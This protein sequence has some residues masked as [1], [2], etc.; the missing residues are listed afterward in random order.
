MDA[1]CI[2]KA[3]HMEVQTQINSMFRWF[4]SASKC[5]VFLSDVS[6]FGRGT[7]QA[8]WRTD[9]RRSRWFTRAWT[10]QELLAPR[11]VEFFSR[12]GTTLGTKIS[13]EYELQSITQLPLA[14][15]QGVSLDSFSVDERL[16]WVTNRCVVR[17]EDLAYSLLGIFGVFMPILYGEGQKSALSRLRRTIEDSMIISANG[18]RFQARD[19]L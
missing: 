17:Q 3:D 5:Y 15:L 18:K 2:N 16:S 9:F 10:L 4:N 8:S 7:G 6:A 11:H 12:E 19:P 14:A 13:L 1:C